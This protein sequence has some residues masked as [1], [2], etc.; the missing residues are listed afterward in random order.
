[1]GLCIPRTNF[2]PYRTAQNETTQ[3]MYNAVVQRLSTNDADFD[4]RRHGSQ[5]SRVNKLDHHAEFLCM[6]DL[7]TACMWHRERVRVA[8]SVPASVSHAART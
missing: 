7:P 5:G 4:A 8:P 1:M 6:K 3:I 2:V